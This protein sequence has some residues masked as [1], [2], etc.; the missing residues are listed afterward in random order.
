[1]SLFS[2][3]QFL[4]KSKEKHNISQYNID[5]YHKGIN[6]FHLRKGYS[7]KNIISKD[8]KNFN[9]NPKIIACLALIT[10]CV[11]DKVS[12]NDSIQKYILEISENETLEDLIINYLNTSEPETEF[13]HFKFISEIIKTISG[14]SIEEYSELMVIKPMKMN[15]TVF[16]SNSVTTTSGSYYKLC[17]HISN[18]GCTLLKHKYLKNSIEVFARLTEKTQRG[19]LSYADKNGSYTLIDPKNK[20]LVIYNQHPIY[21]TGNQYI[22]F[23]E[24]QTFIYDWLKSGDFPKGINLFP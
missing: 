12:L 5:I 24:L 21:I 2:L 6:V 15:S 4:D 13:K 16:S 10:L 17:N 7:F 3:Q 20:I 18:Y 8:S 22:L 19:Y 1:M 9:V 11:N 23:D 14:Y